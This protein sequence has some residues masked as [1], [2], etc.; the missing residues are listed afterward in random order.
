[1]PPALI[2]VLFGCC[3]R[4]LDGDPWFTWWTNYLITRDIY[5]P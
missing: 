4:K 2:G 5:F 1:M 3:G